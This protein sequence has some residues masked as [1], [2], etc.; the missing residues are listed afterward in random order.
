MV[1]II[2]IDGAGRLVLPVRMRRRLHL[3]AGCRLRVREEGSTIVL[4]PV[5]EESLPVEKDGLLV[6]P[7]RIDDRAVDHRIVRE[8]RLE[9]L[10]PRP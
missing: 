2:V 1:D 7:G 5:P 9:R 10:T 8:E 3:V 4:E 6:A